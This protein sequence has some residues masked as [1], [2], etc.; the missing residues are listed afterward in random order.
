MTKIRLGKW[1]C[2]GTNSQG[3][4]TSLVLPCREDQ[5]YSIRKGHLPP[6]IGQLTH[7]KHLDV[8]V[9]ASGEFRPEIGQLTQLE[10]LRIDFYIQDESH[11]PP[12]LL[13]PEWANL[14]KLRVLDVSSDGPI[15]AWIGSL[16]ALEVLD[17]AKSDVSPLPLGLG[18]LTNLRKLRTAGVVGP[19]PPELGQL[20]NLDTLW[21]NGLWSGSIPPQWGGMSNL[22]FLALWGVEEANLGDK[23]GFSSSIPASLGQMT[24]L[25]HLSISGKSAQAGGVLPASLGQMTKLKQFGITG[26]EGE[27]PAEWSGWREIETIWIE[28]QVEGQLPE[29]WGFMQSLERLGLQN[30]LLEGPLPAIWSQMKNLKALHL[31][32]NFI[33]SPLPAEWGFMESL[34]E[35][36]IVRSGLTGQLPP[37]WGNLSNLRIL[38][39]EYNELTGTI[40]ETWGNMTSLER[41]ALRYN[42]LGG[43][44]PSFLKD[45]SALTSIRSIRIHN[46]NTTWE[47][48]HPVNMCFSPDLF[49]SHIQKA[50]DLYLCKPPSDRRGADYLLGG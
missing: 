11:R 36:T 16:S 38:N 40:P 32:N 14:Q 1:D 27:L 34:E 28:G 46:D 31:D 50:I 19:L 22:R 43:P 42:E 8:D 4:V 12:K 6:E 13:P 35:L 2:V 26:A 47:G 10:H 5:N 21:I 18:Q 9:N 48:Y 24:N 23:E 20:T 41:L 45:P 44:L 15:P 49:P 30:N 3:R 37:E 17:I 29:E 25:E 39:L 7:L 33:D